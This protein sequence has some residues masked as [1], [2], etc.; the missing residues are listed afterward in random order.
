ML[1]HKRGFFSSEIQ[2]TSGKRKIKLFLKN[3]QRGNVDDFIGVLNGYAGQR[4]TVM[5]SVHSQSLDNLPVETNHDRIKSMVS[6]HE[7]VTNAI[8]ISY[9]GCTVF[10][11]FIVLYLKFFS[12]NDLEKNEMQRP[13]KTSS[14]VKY[15]ANTLVKK[16]YEK[17][18]KNPVNTQTAEKAQDQSVKNIESKK[19]Q[20]EAAKPTIKQITS[21]FEQPHKIL[22]SLKSK[23]FNVPH[24]WQPSKAFQGE[25]YG[26]GGTK[27]SVNHLYQT[28]Y[29]IS[30]AIHG[31]SPDLVDQIRLK[32]VINSQ[33]YKNS[34]LNELY[35]VSETLFKSLDIPYPQELTNLI[36]FG[37]SG[38]IK[39]N[40]GDVELQYEKT[41]LDWFILIINREGHK[42]EI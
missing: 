7:T 1:K 41:S 39:T 16:V 36:C 18:S 20:K 9:F 15:K 6:R 24:E 23:G 40:F 2:I 25:Y 34:A 29:T 31:L 35:L 3:S 10:L 4:Q 30:F 26:N 28:V 33:I 8:L 11:L 27:E 22:H 38:K 37:K 32:L 21:F 14:S 42:F 5:P 12:G 13:V 19:P 17:T